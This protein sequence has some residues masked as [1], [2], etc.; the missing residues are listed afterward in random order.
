MKLTHFRVTNYRNVLDSGCIEVGDITAF[1]GQ[2]EA[3][4]SNNFE[5]LYRINPFVPNEAYKIDED[6]PV[7]D[8][9]NKDPSAVVCRAKFILTRDEIESLYDEAAL[10]RPKRSDEDAAGTALGEE[11]AI[12]LPSELKLVGSRSYNSGPTFEVVGEHAAEFEP[13]K[14]DT[15]AKRHAPKFVL[16]QDY[17]LIGTQIE[18]NQLAERIK[19]VSWHQLTNEEQTI[20]IVLDLAKIDITEFLAKGG[21]P[22]GRTV[23]ELASRIRTAA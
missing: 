13:A 23:R 18:L 5:A 3:G 8:W 14:V 16:I 12:E 2:N 4:K 17:G 7:D 22:E 10:P 11:E 15:W 21:T 1:V 20:K 19:A 9:G 6:W